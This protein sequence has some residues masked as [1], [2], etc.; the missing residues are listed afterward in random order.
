MSVNTEN[1]ISLSI[2]ESGKEDGARLIEGYTLDVPAKQPI[3]EC[4]SRTDYFEGTSYK[5]TVAE[6]EKLNS[7]L[8]KSL[9][10]IKPLIESG[11]I[12]E[13]K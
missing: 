13:V 9:A 7:Q 5:L 12:R 4:L 6:A 3:K 10:F 1:G 11:K 8:G 2:S